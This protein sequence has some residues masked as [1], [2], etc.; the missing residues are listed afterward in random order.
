MKTLEKIFMAIAFAEEGEFDTAR[1]IM[2]E[3]EVR[4]VD[5]V[6]LRKMVAN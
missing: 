2:K 4:C 1:D 6:Q 3:K 5:R